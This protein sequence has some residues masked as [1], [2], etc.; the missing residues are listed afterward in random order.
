MRSSLA[1][2]LETGS[3]VYCMYSITSEKQTKTNIQH[4]SEALGVWKTGEDTLKEMPQDSDCTHKWLL[5]SCL[6]PG[7]TSVCM[8]DG[9]WICH[10]HVLKS[11]FVMD[12][13]T[14]VLKSLFPFMPS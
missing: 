6:F 7:S 9:A 2:C 11:F 1:K 12:M 14:T 5:K 4:C 10:R 8:G 3:Y 13:E